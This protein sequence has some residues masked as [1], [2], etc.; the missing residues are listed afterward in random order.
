MPLKDLVKRAAWKKQYY[1]DRGRQLRLMYCGENKEYIAEM[2][3]IYRE[4]NKE[5]IQIQRKL[6]NEEHKVQISNYR[7]VKLICECGSI[8]CKTSKTRHDATQ[9]HVIHI[10]ENMHANNIITIDRTKDILNNWGI[11]LDQV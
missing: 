4:K 2:S 6:Y 10:I 7:K 5:Y 9:K 3:K 11:L 1:E 8:Y